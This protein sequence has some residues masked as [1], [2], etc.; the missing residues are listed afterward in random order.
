MNRVKTKLAKRRSLEHFLQWCIRNSMKI[1]LVACVALVSLSANRSLLGDTPADDW[2]A[3]TRA[4]ARKNPV[5]AD[6]KSIAAGKQ[7]YAGNCLACHGTTGKGDGPAAIALNPKPRDISDPKI[8][9]QT[10][11]ELFWKLTE[12]KKPMPSYEKLLSETDRWS[13]INYVRTLQGKAGK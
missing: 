2:K 13:A 7:A 3:P 6:A 9:S 4:A 5:P 12:G 10:D 1:A 11:G 8:A